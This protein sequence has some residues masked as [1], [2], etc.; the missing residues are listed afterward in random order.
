MNTYTVKEK[1]IYIGELKVQELAE[2]YG[3]PTYV[4]NEK[5]IRENF[6]K[7]YNAFSSHYPNF[8]FFYAIKACNNP[9]IASI[10]K[11]EGAGIDAASI[12]EIK[13]AKSIGL[14]GENVMFSGNFLSDDDIK[15]GLDSGVIFNI[16]DIS[17]LPRVLKIKK[18]EIISFRINPGYGK[19]NVGDFVTNAGPNAKFGI[20]P[21]QVTEAYKM[22]KD[23]G[24]KRFG[25]HMM[26]GSCLLDPEYFAFVT[27]L[28]MDIVGKT[29]KELNINFEFIDIGGGLGIPYRDDENELDLDLTAKKVAETFKKAIQKYSLKPP[30]LM[31]EPARYFLANAGI[32]IGKV[33]SIKN[34]YRKILGTD[35]GMNILVRP[36]FYGS[37]HKILFD[38]RIGDSEEQS[39]L[40]GQLCEN[41]DYWIKERNFPKTVKEGDIVIATDAGAYGYGMSYQY[42]GRLKPAEVLVNGKE[43]YLIR[44][45]EK[46][47][48][49]LTGTHL[50]EYL[51]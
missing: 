9:A 51:F 23:A 27:G 3:T 22:A 19:S 47:E 34:S 50:P 41:T 2:K 4:Y 44:E 17:I 40:C 48:D 7:A 49:L 10:L 24:I 36:A 46:F 6:R 11:Q 35:I 20:H 39:G 16:D 26:P 42:N 5:K 25:V 43:S 32:V 8:K 45:R 30:M 21:D 18:P 29:A 1:Q 31:M 12:N 37:Y 14:D 15:E 33:H 38:G 28:L 13:L